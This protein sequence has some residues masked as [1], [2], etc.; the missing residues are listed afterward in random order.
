M[1]ITI[2]GSGTS[3]G[4]PL[5][6]CH[7]EVCRSMD[8]RDHR[9]RPSI[10]VQ[11][12]D[13][14][15]LIDTGPDLRTQMLPTKVQRLD[16]VLYTHQHKDHT[17]GMDDLRAFYYAQNQT[18]IP[19]YAREEVISQLKEEYAYVFVDNDKKYPGVLDVEVHYIENKPFCIGDV[20]IIPIEVFHH[21][22]PVFGF[23]IQDFTYI[24]DVNFIPA[25]EMPKIIGSKILMLDALRREPHIAHY[26]LEQ[27]VEVAQQI[28]AEKTFF[29]HISHGLGLHKEV[30]KELP[31]NIRLAYDGLVLE[32]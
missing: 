30:E 10:L 7:C 15:I 1:K 12:A 9:L 4:V 6:G 27:A 5:I 24:T 19:I 11:V 25:E 23:R 14:N 32:L 8:F 3:L 16:A 31:E 29:T 28:Q 18:P 20:E 22:L 13:Q 2:L 26:T 17:A 21:K